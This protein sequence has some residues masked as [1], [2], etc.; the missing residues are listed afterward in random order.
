MNDPITVTAA[1]QTYDRQWLEAY[2]KANGNP[3]TVLC[4]LTRLP[5]QRI[6]LT[7]N[8]NDEVKQNIEQFVSQQETKFQHR[9]QAHIS[10]SSS[11][12][13]SNVGMFAHSESQ[14]GV[15]AS[16]T[17]LSG[18]DATSSSNFNSG[19]SGK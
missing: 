7:K 19:G 5:I 2:F 13:V 3:E 8:T 6:E 1:N 10:N 16:S 18:E 15:G 9:A 14:Q 17:S 11:S 4:P 12:G